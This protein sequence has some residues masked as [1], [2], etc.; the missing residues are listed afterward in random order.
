MDQELERI[1][2]FVE[3]NKS[4]VAEKPADKI[5][6]VFKDKYRSYVEI[7]CDKDIELGLL[8]KAYGSYTGNAIYPQD[9]KT[10]EENLIKL[11]DV[12]KNPLAANSLGYIY[13]YGRTNNGVSDYEKALKYFTIAQIAGI[14][15]AKYKLCDMLTEGKGFPAKMPEIAFKSISNMYNELLNEFRGETYSCEFADVAIRMGNYYYDL[16]KKGSCSFYFAYQYYMIA[17]YA[18]EL[19]MKNDPQYG[20]ESVMKRLMP[21]YQDAKEHFHKELQDNNAA[22]GPL[23]ILEDFLLNN[24]ARVQVRKLKDAKYKIIITMNPIN[25]NNAFYTKELVAIPHLDYCKL[26]SKIELV[27]GKAPEFT[28][29]KRSNFN[30]DMVEVEDDELNFCI[31]EDIKDEEEGVLLKVIMRLDK[32]YLGISKIE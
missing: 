2:N 31:F 3:D 12:C 18:L 20:D 23:N 16:A 4:F 26:I 10:A 5:P 30:I 27:S 25:P 28:T 8:E 1:Y 24:T 22:D 14:S 29:S 21:K 32:E 11:V 7:L 15:E 6:D 17:K 19:R 9:W 13:Y